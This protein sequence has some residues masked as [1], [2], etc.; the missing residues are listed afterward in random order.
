MTSTSLLKMILPGKSNKHIQCSRANLISKI[1]L[2]FRASTRIPRLYRDFYIVFYHRLTQ[3]T[4][5][6]IGRIERGRKRKKEG[7]GKR[8]VPP[9][10]YSHNVDLS[11]FSRRD[12]RYIINTRR[13]VREAT[14]NFSHCSLLSRGGNSIDRLNVFNAVRLCV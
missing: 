1:L 4:I 3:W 10:L 9:P 14:C 5:R 2:K 6:N 7:E 12:F 8:S 11:R 13:G